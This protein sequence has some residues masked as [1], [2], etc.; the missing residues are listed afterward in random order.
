MAVSPLDIFRAKKRDRQRLAMV[1]LYDAP[2]AV[3]CCD[4]GVDVLLVGDS[5]GNVILG[6]ANFISVDM[7]DMVRHTAAVVRG[8]QQSTRPD[9]PVVADMPFGSFH[10]SADTII[11]N[12]AA[13]IQAGASAVKLE[14]AGTSALKAVDLLVQMGAPVMGH[15]GYTPQS[16]LTLER[17][18]HD[19]TADAARRLVTEAKRLEQA[20][21]FALVLEVVR[22]EVAARITEEVGIATIGIGAGPHCD[23]QVLIWHELAGM[24]P[25]SYR[26]VKRYA[27]THTLLEQAARDY[28]R[29]V[30]SGAFPTRE[31][32]WSMPEPDVRS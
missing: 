11:R 20:G 30:Q 21:C 19:K 32:G 16:A 9:V 23:G 8:V 2:S 24:K 26:F 25:S 7:E 29:E 13:L 17:V 5:L 14:G 3:L 6:N 1:S 15:L 27:E 4:N 22:I 31:H 12:G 28:V 10:G 18:V